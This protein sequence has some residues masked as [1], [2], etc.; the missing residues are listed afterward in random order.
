VDDKQVNDRVHRIGSEIHDNIII[1]DYVTSNT[2]EERVREVLEGKAHSFEEVVKDKNQLLALLKEN[3][4][5]S[6]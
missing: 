4:K 3:R 1:T 2:V 6:K 5:G